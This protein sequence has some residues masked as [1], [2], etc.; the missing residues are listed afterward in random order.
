MLSSHK[1]DC[2]LSDSEM[3]DIGE[4]MNIEVTKLNAQMVTM[5]VEMAEQFKASN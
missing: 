2:K 5:R 4:K 1:I 3:D